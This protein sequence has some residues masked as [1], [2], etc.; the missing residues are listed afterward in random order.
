MGLLSATTTALT[1]MQAAETVIDV[2]GNN[3]ANSNTVGFKQSSV[4]FATQF[5]QTQSIGSAPSGNLGGT[6]PRQ[7]GLGVKVSSISPNFNQGTIEISA[8]PLDIAI[9]GD[10]FLV[11][12]GNQGEDL[13]TRNGQ[14]KLN[15]AN[16]LVTATGQRL[17]GYGIDSDF[18]IEPGDLVPL[19]IPLG[20][21]RVVRATENAV[22]SGVLNPKVA[23]GATPSTVE[24]VTL[25]TADVEAP[26]TT[27]FLASSDLQKVESPAAATATEASSGA[28]PFP[29]AGAYRYRIVFLDSAG[30][31]G[32]PSAEFSVT[33]T[34]S[35]PITISALP[36]ADGTTFTQRRI[37]RTDAGG[38]TFRRLGTIADASTTTT[39]SDTITDSVLSG[40]PTLSA[41]GLEA[42]AYSYYVTYYNPT[43]LQETRPSQNTGTVTVGANNRIRINLSETT[44][45]ADAGFTQKRLYRNANGASTPH[46]RVA[47]MPVGQTVYMDSTP[48][49]TLSTAPRLDLDG[50]QA[51]N[52]TLLSDVL[53]RRGNEYENL[54]ELGLPDTNGVMGTLSLAG[55]KGNVQLEAKELEIKA[56]TTVQ[57]LLE[58]MSQALGVHEESYNANYPL[59]IGAGAVSIVNGKL[60][61][62]SN[63]GEQNAIDVG[64][65]SFQLQA[66]GSDTASPV[67]LAF[68]ETVSGDGP[69]TSSEFVV[70]D[71]VGSPLSVR[72]TT[73]R[74]ESDEQGVTK[75]RWYANSASNQPSDETNVSTVVGNGVLRFDSKGKL[76]D[77]DDSS[78]SILLEQT[79]AE[80]PLEVN[81]DFSK[82]TS[83]DE[84]DAQNNEISTLN[85]TRQ[86]GFPPGVLTD[87]IITDSGRIQGQFSNGTQRDL[88]QIVMARFANNEGL[89]QVGDSLF[90]VGVNSGD[91][92]LGNPGNN[93]IGT[94]TAGATELSNTDI[95]Q[96]LIKLVLA[97]TQ[98]RGGAR[99]ITAAQELLDE[100]LAIRR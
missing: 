39:F 75:Y 43:T 50:P 86:D 28:A 72:I 59:P 10:G 92:Q 55:E 56:D 27:T 57:D 42:G 67:S 77:G 21:S 85:M 40:Q 79:A 33:S 35:F 58:F 65:T 74:E 93:G 8:N 17:L 78:I 31:E 3:V 82:V 98:Y 66:T 30:N 1:G 44:A 52:G 11:V 19:T 46:Y 83:L 62:I 87:F 23:T 95:G 68:S 16:E 26:T 18:N 34:G 7:V 48:S 37:Y 6:N 94:L 71:S 63:L 2:V 54:F 69:G 38:S 25:G 76:L 84:R 88:G 89:Q 9:Q 96:N 91:P 14:L 12:Q 80:S 51:N 81:L 45:P 99:V 24:S 36:N 4:I 15:S 32:P 22:F 64:L 53:I 100:L 60:Q 29:A 13:Y 20:D 5:L 41:T 61:I 90:N 70:Y 73:V 47:E 49:T 97:S